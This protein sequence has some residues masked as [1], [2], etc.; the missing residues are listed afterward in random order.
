MRPG[1]VQ[2]VPRLVLVVEDDPVIADLLV[3]HLEHAGYRTRVERDGEAAL[4]A[5]ARHTPAVVLL[6][7]GLPGRDGI[8]VCRAMR[9]AGDWTPVLFV[10]ARDDHV[11]RVVGLELGADDYVTK[12]FSPREVT[13]RVAAVLRRAD[14]AREHSAAIEVVR[15]GAVECLPMERR[16]LVQGV[17]VPFTAT[18]FELLHFLLC[19]PGRVFSRSQLLRNV[20][21]QDNLAGERTV[22]VHVAQ[23]RAKLA[24][25]EVIRTVRGVGYAA[26]TERERRP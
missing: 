5:V 20:W 18:E 24:P 15:S 13:A 16:V 14:G 9:A 19:T 8:E 23:V 2:T 22:D 4:A 26:L 17:E 6:D 3:L 10:T 7:I 1:A 25:H 21:G 12:P 11:D